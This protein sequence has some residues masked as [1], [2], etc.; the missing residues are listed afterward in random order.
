MDYISEG[1]KKGLIKFDDE[2]KI[3]TYVQNNKK[4]RYNNSEEHVRLI[5]YLKLILDFRYKAERISLEVLMPDRVPNNFADIVVYNDDKKKDAHIVVECKQPE[6]SDAEFKQAIEQGFA[7]SAVVSAQYLWVTSS[8]SD[9]Y[10]NVKDFPKGEREENEIPI[11]PIFGQK[12]F[13]EPTYIKGGEGLRAL[14]TLTED[15]LT[16]IFK[17]AHDSLWYGGKRNP[18]EAFDELNKLI[19]CKIYDEKI[20]EEER[21]DG[22]PF[23]F[24]NYPSD[25]GNADILTNRIKKIYQDGRK[26]DPEVFKDDIRISP[27]ELR[28]IVGFLAKINLRDTD[29]DSKGRAFEVFLKDDIFRGKFGQYFTP[30]SIVK[31]IVEVLPIDAKS[32]VLDPSCGSGG[33][34]LYALD[35]VRTIANTKFSP[36]KQPAK[37]Y[38]YWH[39]FAENNLFGIEISDTIARVAKM[40]MIIHDD[41]HTN[42]IAY[43]GLENINKIHMH[44]IKN[45]SRG[46]DKFRE[47]TF[48]Y[49]ITNPPFGSTVKASE[50]SYLG[51]YELG[52]K[53]FDWIDTYLK[54]INPEILKENQQSEV[55]FL[56]QYHEFLKTPTKQLNEG[57]ILASVVPDGILTN[58]TS[59][60]VRDWIEENYRIIAVISLPQMAFTATGAGVKSSLLFLQKYSERTSN[61]IKIKKQT[62]QNNIFKDKSLGGALI[63]AIEEKEYTLKSGDAFIRQINDELFNLLNSLNN[64]DSIDKAT[65]RKHERNA[66]DK[67]KQYKETEAYKNWH[68]SINEEHN[69][70]I[71]DIKEMIEEVY[72]EKINATQNESPNSHKN[73]PIFM[74]IAEDIGYDATGK[75]TF[76]ND[77][78]EDIAPEL[79]RFIE[80]VRNGQ[81]DFF[82]PA[83]Q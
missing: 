31:F 66:N 5:T 33:F 3:V 55:L 2:K 51:D 52:K 67:I 30:R 74:G 60:Y 70:K 76:K 79:K 27:Q 42:I 41:G 7:Y 77:L 53:N 59:Q 44:A 20:T 57:G 9:R 75:P 8:I 10:F 47:E 19:F 54:S 48:D 73:Y 15:E 37:N 81:D 12:E 35:K 58:S 46:Y 49:I 13:K 25:E 6:A 26:Q 23:R 28:T 18:S 45:K 14:K 29:L 50:R 78:D 64:Q 65:I 61:E 11:I 38:K 68:S 83:L 62:I 40:N 71:E 56:E 69:V 34:L 21:E 36:E 82:V 80:A 22:T 63:K 24:Q 72:I 4:Y 16:K 32:N 17:K 43:D 1:L 39:D